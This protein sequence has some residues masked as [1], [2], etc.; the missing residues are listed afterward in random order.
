MA[1]NAAFCAPSSIGESFSSASPDPF[2]ALDLPQPPTLSTA[3]NATA[4]ATDHCIFI[5]MTCTSPA[6]LPNLHCVKA[7][8]N[9]SSPAALLAS[10]LRI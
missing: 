5:F 7:G 10:L 1:V 3:I 8:G 2:P 4:I 6:L 9:P